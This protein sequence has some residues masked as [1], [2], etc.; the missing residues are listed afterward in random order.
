[1][2]GLEE[3]GLLQTGIVLGWYREPFFCLSI[4]LAV[5]LSPIQSACTKHLQCLWSLRPWAVRWQN[6]LCA[7]KEHAVLGRGHL[8][9]RHRR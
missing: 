5:L 3:L 8:Q 2:Q 6:M 1:M 4:P 7:F 9:A